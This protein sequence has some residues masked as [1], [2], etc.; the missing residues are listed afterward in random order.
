VPVAVNCWFVPLAMLGLAGVTVTDTSVAEFTVR[1]VEPDT[2]PDVAVIIA[3]PAATDVDSPLEPAVLL[4][5]AT[6]VEQL[7]VTVLVRSCVVLSEKVPVAVNCWFVPLTML[8]LAGVIAMDTRV[9]LLT[10]RRPHP[11]NFPQVALIVAVPS[12]L[13]YTCP[14][15]LITDWITPL[16]DV[17][18]DPVLELMIATDVSEEL[19]ATVSVRSF[20]ELSE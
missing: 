3:E 9:A 12:P 4:M 5:V 7:Q 8:G 16:V 17:S 2:P 6:P 1:P 18:I 13:A 19:H 10:C 11:Q 20:V 15:M 14:G